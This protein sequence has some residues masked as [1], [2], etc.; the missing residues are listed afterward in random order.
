MMDM[1]TGITAMASLDLVALCAIVLIGLPHGALDGAIAM[2]LG[3]SSRIVVFIRFLFLYIGMAGLVIAAWSLAPAPCLLGF[4]FISMVHFGAGDARHG[5]GWVRGAEVMAH[6]GLVVAGISQMHR[7]EV[8]VIFSYLAGG[9]TRLVWQ[10]LDILTVIVGISLVICVAQALWSR[11]WRTTALE[12]GGL[13]VLFALT[14]PLVGFAVYFCG[15]HSARHVA[16]ILASLRLHMSVSAMLLQALIFTLASWLAGAG[17]IWWLADMSDPEPAL[18]RVVFIGLAALTVPHMILVDGI[19][20]R[21]T[22]ILQRRFIS[23]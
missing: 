9:D 16:S 19:Y 22:R 13:A 12:L 15:V 10:G 14:P 6:G 23:R 11:R 4:L 1:V 17:A 3:F 18:L 7:V 20:R 8:D 2:H 21:T 5:T